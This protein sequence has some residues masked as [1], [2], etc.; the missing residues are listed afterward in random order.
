MS[1]LQ[2]AFKNDLVTWFPD[3]GLY[4]KHLDSF[5]NIELWDPLLKILISKMWNAG[6][7]W[8]FLKIGLD[9]AIQQIGELLGESEPLILHIRMVCSENGRGLPPAVQLK[10][11]L[12]KLKNLPVKSEL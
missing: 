5:Q 2:E 1:E 9:H 7:K 11:A 4:Q 12:G 8:Q 3:A 6:W 10:G